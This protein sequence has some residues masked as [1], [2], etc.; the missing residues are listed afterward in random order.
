MK[1]LKSVKNICCL[2]F[3]VLIPMALTMVS[4]FWGY[5]PYLY[6][7]ELYIHTSM[8]LHY[9]YFFG[10]S[11]TCLQEPLTNFYITILRKYISNNCLILLHLE[12]LSKINLIFWNSIF[13]TETVLFYNL[14]YISYFRIKIKTI[15]QKYY[16]LII[17]I[18]SCLWLGLYIKYSKFWNP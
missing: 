10:A 2:R 14:H 5:A 11:K 15:L 18:C 6:D 8:T 1:I 7:F 16:K 12:S 3:N 13:D 4:F 9:T 17:F